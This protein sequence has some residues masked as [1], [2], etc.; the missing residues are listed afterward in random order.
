M[1]L[2]DGLPKRPPVELVL[3]A[4][5]ELEFVLALPNRPPPLANRTKLSLHLD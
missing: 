4:P 2:V 1:L 5:K 3:L